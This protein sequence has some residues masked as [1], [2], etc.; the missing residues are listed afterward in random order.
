[1]KGWE[2]VKNVGAAMLLARLK[3][4]LD[5]AQQRIEQGEVRAGQRRAARSSG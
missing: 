3:V 4:R 1:V 5:A 2:T